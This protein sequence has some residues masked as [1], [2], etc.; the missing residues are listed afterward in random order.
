[1]REAQDG[2]RERLQN[3]V[4]SSTE[5][6]KGRERVK[7]FQIIYRYFKKYY[8][9]W[10]ERNKEAR[11]HPTL[12]LYQKRVAEY[13]KKLKKEFEDEQRKHSRDII[14]EAKR[15]QRRRE[16]NAMVKE[17]GEKIL[18]KFASDVAIRDRE[19]QHMHFLCVNMQRWAGDNYDRDQQIAHQ[20]ELDNLVAEKKAH[21]KA[22]EDEI[23]AD[24]GVIEEDIRHTQ[25]VYRQMRQQGLKEGVNVQQK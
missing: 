8:D 1:M 3:V 11:M 25:E 19:A 18:A 12:K 16:I 6:M 24:K 5:R 7:P 21:D 9:R 22:I 4:N 20:A 17:R 13:D 23:K 10:Y 14:K 15:L 2:A